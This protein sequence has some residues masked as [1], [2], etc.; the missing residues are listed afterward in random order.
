MDARISKVG[1]GR[2]I[3]LGHRRSSDIVLVSGSAEPT[4]GV[5]EDSHAA[6][7][8]T[9]LLAGDEVPKVA[10]IMIA[11]FEVAHSHKNPTGPT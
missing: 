9:I 6:D 4:F 2:L 7:I 10:A 5:L 11:C 3:R 8:P 1:C